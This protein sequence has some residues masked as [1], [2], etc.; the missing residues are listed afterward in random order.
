LL[1]AGLALLTVG[2]ELLVRGA[3]ALALALRVSPLVVGLTIVAYGTSAPEMVVSVQSSLQGQADI[4]VGNVVGSNIFNVLFILGVSA[5]ITPLAVAQQLVRFDVPLMIGLSVLTGLLGWDGELGR[6]DG[7][8]F[9]LGLIAYT[10]WVAR[11]GP[12]EPTAVEAEYAEA[13]GPSPAAASVGRILWH[14]LLVLVGLGLL[15][16][17]SRLFVGAAVEIARALGVS[18]LVIGLTLVAA[19]TSLPEVATSVLAA[20]K[21]ERDIAV[22]N[23]VGSNLFNILG[24]LGV[25]AVVAPAGVAVSPAALSFDIPVMIATAIACLPV[26]FTGHCIARWEGLVF[27]GY[28]AAYVAYLVLAASAPAAGSSLALWM[29]LFVIPLTVVT[30]LVGVVRQLRHGSAA[31]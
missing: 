3:A 23:V 21:G 24:V 19:G 2:A 30:L 1:L 4:A 14:V 13:L 18:E 7:L 8:I 31:Q 10:V 6:L 28:Y 29:G 9:I 17:G 16:W 22:G 15:V 11:F 12:K 26:F 27:L 25:S 20:I 5:L